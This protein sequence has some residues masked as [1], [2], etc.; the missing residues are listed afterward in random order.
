MRLAPHRPRRRKPPAAV[1]PLP[2]MCRGALGLY[3]RHNVRT[4]DVR[5]SGTLLPFA[6]FECHGDFIVS[7][8]PF[9]ARS[10]FTAPTVTFWGPHAAVQDS[11][12][13]AFPLHPFLHGVDA[14]ETVEHV[15]RGIGRNHAGLPAHRL[16]RLR[17][18][19]S[20]QHL[21]RARAHHHHGVGWATARRHQCHRHAKPV[22]LEVGG[23]G[24]HGQ[25]RHVSDLHDDERRVLRDRRLP[26]DERIL[27]QH[28]LDAP[29]GQRTHHP[30]RQGR[31]RK[32]AKLHNAGVYRGLP[33]P[34]HIECLLWQPAAAG[35]EPVQSRA[36]CRPD[37]RRHRQVRCRLY[38]GP[39][40][41]RL[42]RG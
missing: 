14:H 23:R 25:P 26:Q 22:C 15:P 3:Q 30:C 7:T 5:T 42:L 34:R 16:Q 8:K 29:A 39:G 2:G 18:R 12:G 35:E 19:H 9:A 20:R 32:P 10:A 33:G 28:V 40:A 13:F 37:H 4:G 36:G 1:P 17:R 21:R 27:W 41:G 31:Q 38:P 24:V 6:S 11:E